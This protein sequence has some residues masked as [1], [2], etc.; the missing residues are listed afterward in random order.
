M[1]VADNAVYGQELDRAV[2]PYAHATLTAAATRG[3]SL[4]VV[5]LTLPG[6][7][8]RCQTGTCL[9]YPLRLAG[10][11]LSCHSGPYPEFDT[12]AR[13]AGDRVARDIERRASRTP[14]PREAAQQVSHGRMDLDARAYLAA[15]YPTHTCRDIGDKRVGNR[16][17]CRGWIPVG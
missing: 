5:I 14:P 7:H 3:I 13:H 11:P 2:L 12:L 4:L 9:A 8:R 16:A 1:T 17:C 10:P 15:T 6:G